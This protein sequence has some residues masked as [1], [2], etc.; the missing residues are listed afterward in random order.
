MVKANSGLHNIIL[1]YFKKILRQTQC[2]RMGV[3]LRRSL[4]AT[5]RLWLHFIPPHQRGKSVQT[6]KKNEVQC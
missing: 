1:I 2:W 6:G 4:L 3:V 5:Q